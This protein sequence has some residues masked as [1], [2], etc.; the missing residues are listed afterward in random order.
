MAQP[1][2]IPSE[3][4]LWRRRRLEEAARLAER[5][6]RTGSARRIRVG[7]REVLVLRRPRHLPPTRP[8]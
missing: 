4:L 7:N 1:Q 3:I 2:S 8:S 6:D 5:T